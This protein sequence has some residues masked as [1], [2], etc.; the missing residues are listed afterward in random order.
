M[1]TVSYTIYQWQCSQSTLD[2]DWPCVHSVLG[3]E[4]VH[5]LNQLSL[6]QCQL[7]VERQGLNHC[8]VAEFYSVGAYQEFLQRKD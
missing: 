4:C 6:D 1:K 2:I 3:R 5:W 7:I 8:L